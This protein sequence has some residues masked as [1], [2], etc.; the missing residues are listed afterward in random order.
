MLPWDQGGAVGAHTMDA[1]SEM[2]NRVDAIILAS[3]HGEEALGC[4]SG[5]DQDGREHDGN[6]EDEQDLGQRDLPFAGLAPVSSG[7]VEQGAVHRIDPTHS[8]C[9]RVSHSLSEK[10]RTAPMWD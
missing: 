3:G 10:S 8:S 4:P 2:A 5:S 9:A 6:K 1:T 7:A